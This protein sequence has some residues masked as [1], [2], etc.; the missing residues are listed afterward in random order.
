MVWLSRASTPVA[1]GSKTCL[2]GTAT[3]E[4]VVSDA[5]VRFTLALVALMDAPLLTNDERS[6]LITFTVSDP[7][8]ESFD[9]SPRP[10]VALVAYVSF[11]ADPSPVRVSGVSTVIDGAVSVSVPPID[12]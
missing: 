11:D 8:I 7:A 2:K 12:A 4:L 5:D 1:F 6:T 3:A 10:D 9:A